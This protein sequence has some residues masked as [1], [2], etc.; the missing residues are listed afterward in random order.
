M[1]NIELMNHWV[2]SSDRDFEVVQ[3]LFKSKRYDHALFF[4]HLVLEKLFKALFA[5]I[6]EKAPIAPKIH[7][8][9]V[10]A[11]KCNLELD[12]ETHYKLSEINSF[13]MNARYDHIKFEFYKRCTKE[14]S[15]KKLEII[16]EIREWVKELI[17]K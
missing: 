9:V 13:N 16:K 5:K 7:N 8:L 4:A 15:M 6:H 10:L 12:D 2:E 17:K 14:Y 11:E 1:K 3:D